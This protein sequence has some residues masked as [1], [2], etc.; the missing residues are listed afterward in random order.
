[1]AK[2]LSS[3]RLLTFNGEG[4]TA[5]GRDRCVDDYVDAYLV[6]L[7]LPA[8]GTQCGQPQARQGTP[9]TEASPAPQSSGS[10]PEAT[11][12]APEGASAGDIEWCGRQRPELRSP[13][14]S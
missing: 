4:H 6:N 14:G 3:A 9:P 13:S 5:Y 7:E 2:E 11:A 10:Q 1:M 8:E 12:D